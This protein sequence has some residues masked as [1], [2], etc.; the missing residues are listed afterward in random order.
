ME[1]QRREKLLQIEIKEVLWNAWE[2]GYKQWDTV[3]KEEE[4]GPSRLEQYKEK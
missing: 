4:E 1:S 2:L 3:S